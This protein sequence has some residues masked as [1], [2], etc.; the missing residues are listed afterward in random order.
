MHVY[1]IRKLSGHKVEI[2]IEVNPVGVT[3]KRMYC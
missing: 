2:D 3:W 1:T